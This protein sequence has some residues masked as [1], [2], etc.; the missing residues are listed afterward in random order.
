MKEGLLWYDNDPQ[1]NLADK[2]GQAAT[3]YQAKFGRKATVCYLNEAELNG[4]PRDIRGIRLLSNPNVLRHHFLVG[5]EN[6]SIH[7]KV[8]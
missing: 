8:A 3:R 2:V 5:E 6:R 1:R 7:K 4:Q